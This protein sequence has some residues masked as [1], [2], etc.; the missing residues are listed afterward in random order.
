MTGKKVSE[1]WDHLPIARANSVFR[2]FIIV[3]NAV[4]VPFFKAQNLFGHITK[5]LKK[6]NQAKGIA[7]KDWGSKVENKLFIKSEF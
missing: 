3:L 1:A 4:I 2:F 5:G 6:A 7:I